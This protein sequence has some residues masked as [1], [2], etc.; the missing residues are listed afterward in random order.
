M[1]LTHFG[2]VSRCD[3]TIR[4]CASNKNLKLFGQNRNLSG[5]FGQEIKR[6]VKDT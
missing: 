6:N 3:V 1:Y 2:D 4:H 5:K